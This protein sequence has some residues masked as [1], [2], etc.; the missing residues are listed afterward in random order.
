MN[1][2]W[3]IALETLSWIEL[4]RLNEDAALSKTVKQLEV[5]DRE[6]ID[7]AFDLVFAVLERQNTVDY[8]INKSI[9]PLELKD[10]YIG[11]RSFLRLFT[12]MTH[13]SGESLL[14]AYRFAEHANGMLGDRKIKPVKESLDIIPHY[15]VPWS[16]LDEVSKLSFKYFH[17][18]WYVKYLLDNFE[19]AEE[20]MRHID[21]PDYLRINTLKADASILDQL[22]ADGFQLFEEPMLRN[23]Y[24]VLAGSGRLSESRLFQE[25][26]FIIQDKAS[27]LVGEIASPKPS[28]TVLDICAAPGAKTSHLAQ[29]MDNKGRIVSVD[30]DKRRLDSWERLIDRLGVE[31]A[32]SHL[33]DATKPEGLPPV[34][35]DLVVL[36]PPCTGTGTFNK[37]PSSK[38][39]LTQRSIERMASLQRRMIENASTHVKPGGSLVYSTCSVTVEENEGV[40][41]WFLGKHPEFRLVDAVPRIGSSGLG[42][43]VEAQRLYPHLHLCNGFFVA[44]LVRD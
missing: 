34:E 36:D 44:K 33:G 38:W 24:R 43:L 1:D 42:D 6:I 3:T 30:Y 29:L 17:P 40:V 4:Q 8:I 41:N 27:I 25:G 11:V 21:V 14:N 26:A 20:M 22:Y 18:N 23:T 7:T 15:E 19:E 28:D 13:Y 2:T 10:L 31:N 16:E 5:N 35:A 9:E 37:S 32:Y 39:R 12:Y